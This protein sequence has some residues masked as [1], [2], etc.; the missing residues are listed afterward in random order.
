MF[1]S[2]KLM[3]RQKPLQRGK[4]KFCA[5]LLPIILFLAF[6]LADVAVGSAEARFW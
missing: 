2:P 3:L 4:L 5:R 1:F 6:L